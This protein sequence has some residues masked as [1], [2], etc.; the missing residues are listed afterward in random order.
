MRPVPLKF[1]AQV[2]VTLPLFKD[3]LKESFIEVSTT[4]LFYSLVKK[5]QFKCL[6]LDQLTELVYTWHKESRWVS[7]TK[8]EASL[9]DKLRKVIISEL[10]EIHLQACMENFCL[11]LYASIHQR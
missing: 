6:N 7:N 11:S 4:T 1:I 2:H 5:L 3:S 9:L 10:E 8:I